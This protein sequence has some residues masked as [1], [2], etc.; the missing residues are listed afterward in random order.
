MSIQSIIRNFE[1]SYVSESWGPQLNI[2]PRNWLQS[3]LK[4]DKSSLIGMNSPL[5]HRG[6]VKWLNDITKAAR[7]VQKK[8]SEYIACFVTFDGNAEML[9]YFS[10]GK[11]FKIVRNN[12]NKL[13]QFP[14]NGYF[15]AP[16]LQDM[17]SKSASNGNKNWTPKKG[18][19]IDLY[20]IGV[21]QN[22]LSKRAER[23]DVVD[24]KIKSEI[25]AKSTKL[26]HAV[27]DT[28]YEL[29]QFSKNELNLLL[30][31]LDVGNGIRTI[32]QDI[33]KL[34]RRLREI[35]I[36]F[37]ENKQLAKDIAL[38]NNELER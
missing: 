6:S 14:I 9:I 37:N 25:Q 31:N 13:T 17:I 3:I 29:D 18:L 16:E 24:S 20:M 22:R 15:K 38:L 12:E 27:E 10:K 2:V 4:S 33:F 8:G 5:I 7:E 23:D 36:K 1:F 32:K 11:G 26:Q 35:S 21:D 19:N 30:E 28:I 34:S